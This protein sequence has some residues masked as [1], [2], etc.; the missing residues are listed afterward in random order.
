[1]NN[2]KEVAQIREG[3][4]NASDLGTAE[5][6]PIQQNVN[7]YRWINVTTANVYN[8]W[9]MTSRKTTLNKGT[10]VYVSYKYILSNGSQVAK[11]NEGYVNANDLGT[12]EPIPTQQNVNDYRWINVTTA[13]VYNDW[14]M[15][16]RKT[17]L[18]KGT[19]V[20]VNYKYILSNGSQVA[21]INE[22]YVNANDLG[23]AEPTPTQQ[24]INDYRWIIVTI[25]NVYD[26]WN[27][28]NRKTTTLG[29]GTKVYVSYKY[30]LSNG[31][32]VAKIN[33][34]YVNANDLGT[35]NPNSI[36]SNNTV[37]QS[38]F[39]KLVNYLWDSKND[40]ICQI[41]GSN[42]FKIKGSKSA[43]GKWWIEGD[44]SILKSKFKLNNGSGYYN[45]A[46]LL[47]N[48]DFI[49]A[50][51]VKKIAKVVSILELGQN[52]NNVKKEYEQDGDLALAIIKGGKEVVCSIVPP[53][54]SVLI[55]E[56]TKF[57][58]AGE[59]FQNYF[60]DNFVIMGN[61]V[62]RNNQNRSY[63]GDINATNG[64]RVSVDLCCVDR[65]LN[66]C[67]FY[68]S[69]ARGGKLKV[70]G[71]VQNINFPST[72]W[73]IGQHCVSGNNL[74]KGINIIEFYG[75]Y[76]TTY[77]PDIYQICVQD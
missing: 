38:E 13:N 73:G 34:G 64:F 76:N 59:I 61:A 65:P 21:K 25:A 35:A 50:A 32:Q 71:I 11:I 30:I 44:A 4:V 72:N 70:N 19:K 53:W 40:L 52:I 37:T 39:N 3:Y 28:T 23:T 77:A 6:T 5:P 58:K 16:S 29:K 56:L 24:N 10:K 42:L 51:G 36:N 18:N 26:D 75:G 20:Y 1:M 67:I 69:D 17:T 60:P 8:D 46:D 33:E 9:N 54:A 14:N 49:V 47:N 57:Q 66:I 22:G 15:T 12:S 41:K 74:K 62:K 45:T 43:A 55:N 31:N 7:D 27:L 63:I 68:A 2:G 48:E